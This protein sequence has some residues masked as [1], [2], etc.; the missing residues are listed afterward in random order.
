MDANKWFRVVVQ[1]SAGTTTIVEAI[2]NTTAK[3]CY[4]F[5]DAN[6]PL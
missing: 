6:I 2:F 3:V 1:I 5:V 4:C